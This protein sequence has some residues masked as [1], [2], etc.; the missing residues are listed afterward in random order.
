MQML[1]IKCCVEIRTH[2]SRRKKVGRNG[3]A[4][5]QH[6]EKNVNAEACEN[7]INFERVYENPHSPNQ[8]TQS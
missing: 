3:N 2:P 7:N 6:M 8:K 4:S 1:I 5:R